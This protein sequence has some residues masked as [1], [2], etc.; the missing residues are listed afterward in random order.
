M[1]KTR[2]QGR[3]KERRDGKQGN[4]KK[5]KKEQ[6]RKR[7]IRGRT[8]EDNMKGNAAKLWIK[9]RQNRREK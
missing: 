6:A 5:R 7:R 1:T 4:K 8:G 2:E 9:E 3:G